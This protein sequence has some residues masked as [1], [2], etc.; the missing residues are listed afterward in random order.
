VLREQIRH[1]V[2]PFSSRRCNEF[3]KGFHAR[4][5]FYKILQHA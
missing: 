3:D 4:I 1:F 2:K 5:L